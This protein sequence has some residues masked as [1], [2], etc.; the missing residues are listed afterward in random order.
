M[1]YSIS[2][3]ATMMVMTVLVIVEMEG[4]PMRTPTLFAQ[5]CNLSM[6]RA[7]ACEAKLQLC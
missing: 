2:V 3:A 4:L 5:V 7:L 1:E 6:I